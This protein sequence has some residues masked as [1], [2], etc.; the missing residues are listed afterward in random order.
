M[1]RCCPFYEAWPHHVQIR[2]TAQWEHIGTS[3]E[4][5]RERL[6]EMARGAVRVAESESVRAP[7][8]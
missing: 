6:F 3:L 4:V 5:A 1:S 7:I 2:V 8:V